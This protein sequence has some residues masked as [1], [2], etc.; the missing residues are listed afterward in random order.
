MSL[1][2]HHHVRF[3]R[4][5]GSGGMPEWEA[6]LRDR[7]GVTEVRVCREKSEVFVEYDLLECRE[8]DIEHWMV[9]EGF[10]LDDSLMER[11]KRDWIHYT[12]DNELDSMRA[13][14]SCCDTTEIDRKKRKL[15]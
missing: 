10:V 11:I 6:R 1:M 14:H 13:R 15:K 8:T 9:E 12:E 2:K 4:T 7:H 3:T 5:P